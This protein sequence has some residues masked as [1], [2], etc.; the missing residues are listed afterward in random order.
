MTD[1][2][3]FRVAEIFGPT[4]QGEGALA[5]ATTHFV[6]IGGCD[7]RCS[8]CDSLHAVLPDHVARLEQVTLAEIARRVLALPIA[9]WVTLSGGNPALFNLGPLV[10]EL[11][12]EGYAVA[13]ETQGTIWKDWLGAVDQLTISPK[14]PSSGM[15]TPAH[16][17]L[18]DRFVERAY[19]AMG[20]ERI[21]LKI[22]VFDE[23]DLAWAKD[24]FYRFA[25]IP[26]YVSVG[27]RRRPLSLPGTED[28]TINETREQIGDDFAWLCDAVT[29]DRD[30]AFV[31]V[32]PQ[33]HVLAWGHKVGV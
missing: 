24:V 17:E 25:A 6:R 33:L 20:D 31:R 23:A 19:Q 14:P 5:G 28:E 11:Q 27:T 30:L 1:P 9:R 22:V 29:R 18:A 26:C 4:I 15:A 2:A 3:R 32:L 16:E 12:E 7:F 21:A 8:W 13:V 10:V